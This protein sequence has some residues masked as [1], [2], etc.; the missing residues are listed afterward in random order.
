M[1]HWLKITVLYGVGAM[2]LLADL[3][4]PSH[5]ILVVIGLGLF[6]YGLYEAFQ[7]SLAAGV[8]NAVML[9]VALPAGFFIA[10]RNWHRTP[11]GRRI[12]P[13][14]PKLTVQDRLP[15]SD[16]EALLGRTGRSM[17]LLRPVGM[18]EFDGKRFECMA[19]SGVIGIGVEVEAV[20]LSDRTL[21]VRPLHALES[22]PVT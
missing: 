13:P 3:F 17:T 1:D 4:L 15:V 7:I 6:G 5:G 2:I 10:I 8:V 12:S 19:E 18:C 21:V 14:N 9:M 16:M 20:R 11:I 22:A